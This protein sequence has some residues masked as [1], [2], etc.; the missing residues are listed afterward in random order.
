MSHAEAEA[1]AGIASF[2]GLSHRM[3]H[4]ATIDGVTYINDPES[5]QWPQAAANALAH[6]DGVHWIA[7]GRAKDGG[8]AS[9]YAVFLAHPPCLSDRRGRRGF[10][11]DAGR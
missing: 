3:E 7:G 11:Q 2:P 8:I 9:L 6:M 4:V 5:D 1:A 10:R